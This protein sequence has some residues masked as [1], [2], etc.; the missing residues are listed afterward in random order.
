MEA[1]LISKASPVNMSTAEDDIKPPVAKAP[2]LDDD[3]MGSGS[4]AVI[5]ETT[6]NTGELNSLTILYYQIPRHP[7][8]LCILGKTV[9]HCWENLP[10]G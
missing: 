10:T 2:K 7:I 6:G 4:S 9:K 1:I 8:K 3:F 5:L